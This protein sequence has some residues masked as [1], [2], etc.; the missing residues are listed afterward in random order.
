M[1]DIEK[2]TKD[3][4]ADYAERR[5]DLGDTYGEIAE[6]LDLSTSTLYRYRKNRVQ[7][8]SGNTKEKMNRGG[9]LTQLENQRDERIRERSRKAAEESQIEEIPESLPPGEGGVEPKFNTPISFNDFLDKTNETIPESTDNIFGL[10]S[11][12]NDRENWVKGLT[13]K[14]EDGHPVRAE[15][16]LY[17]TPA[18]NRI[19]TTEATE[20]GELLERR[21]FEFTPDDFPEIDLNKFGDLWWERIIDWVDYDSDED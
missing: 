7:S 5:H 8:A 6:D 4:I 11:A 14:L 1:N 20:S 3:R 17:E 13:D 10:G 2:S 9:K 16:F 18:G 15:F 12:F 19:A 21:T